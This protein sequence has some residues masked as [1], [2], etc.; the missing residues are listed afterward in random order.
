MS[1]TALRRVFT[2][3]AWALLLASACREPSL[4]DAELVTITTPSLSV[5]VPSGWDVRVGASAGLEV[6]DPARRGPWSARWLQV[7][8]LDAPTT[9]ACE[10]ETVRT[11]QGQACLTTDEGG[12]SHSSGTGVEARTE[13]HL[14]RLGDSVPEGET[15]IGLPVLVGLMRRVAA[16]FQAPPP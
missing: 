7:I 10:G 5:D 4:A 2:F 12:G 11:R 9:A 6:S 3:A 13:S 8:P 16:S 1:P 14:L 15:P